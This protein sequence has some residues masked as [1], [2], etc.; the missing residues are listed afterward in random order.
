MSGQINFLLSSY[1]KNRRFRKGLAT[2]KIY[3]ETFSK[4]PLLN[5]RLDCYS[6]NITCINLEKETNCLAGKLICFTL[7]D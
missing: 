4:L 1:K 7:S 5:S 2:E 3:K 6:K